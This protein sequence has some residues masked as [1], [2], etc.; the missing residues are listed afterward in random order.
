[1]TDQFEELYQ[2]SQDALGDDAAL[3]KKLALTAYLNQRFGKPF[4]DKTMERLSKREA[5][6]KN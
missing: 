1:M 5:V 4:V 2:L 3:E 6:K